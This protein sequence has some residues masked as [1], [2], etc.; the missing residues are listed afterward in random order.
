MATTRHLRIAPTGPVWVGWA[1]IFFAAAGAAL[2]IAIGSFLT[3]F[4]HYQDSP[5][6]FYLAYA[7]FFLT[8]ALIF[9]V[10]AA[11]TL[12][13]AVPTPQIRRRKLAATLLFMVAGAAALV[14]GLLVA[15]ILYPNPT[16]STVEYVIWLG[17]GVP[18]AIGG[19]IAGFRVLRS[20][21]RSSGDA[22]TE[23][24]S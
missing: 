6:S 16:I 5:D 13:R 20:P 18:L 10:I 15:E 12:N 24:R 17:I 22:T 21:G 1:V 4:D 14:D 9:G 19:P 11:L 7:G 2:S 8:F 23:P 3:V